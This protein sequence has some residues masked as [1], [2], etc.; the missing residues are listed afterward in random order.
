MIDPSEATEERGAERNAQKRLASITFDDGFRSAAESSHRILEKFGYAA[1]FY[2]VTGWVKPERARISERYNV[3]RCHGDWQ[4]WRDMSA[5]GHEIGSHTF[6]H[7]NARGKRAAIFPWLLE[8][9]I[10]RS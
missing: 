3:G 10:R 5:L 4:F 9:D 7:M 8:R 6:S 2:L 1:T